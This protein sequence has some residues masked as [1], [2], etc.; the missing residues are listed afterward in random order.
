MIPHSTLILFFFRNSTNCDSKVFAGEIK[1]KAS[2]K[3]NRRQQKRTMSLSV[4]VCVWIVCAIWAFV[5]LDC[6]Q[7]VCVCV[8]ECVCQR[9]TDTFRFWSGF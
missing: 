1:L 9:H 3:P 6:F 7:R 8:F 5:C 2:N 4:R